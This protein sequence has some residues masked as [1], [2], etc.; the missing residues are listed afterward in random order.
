MN[1]FLIDGVDT[2]A[3]SVL[4][5]TSSDVFI[6]NSRLINFD[7]LETEDDPSYWNKRYKKHDWDHLYG[8]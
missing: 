1:D 8:D 7:K 5:T 2:G 4:S 6:L 3:Q